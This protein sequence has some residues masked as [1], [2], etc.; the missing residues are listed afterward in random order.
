[1]DKSL[2]NQGGLRILAWMLYFIHVV[3]L[4]LCEI[5]WAHYACN[6]GRC[7]ACISR[8]SSTIPAQQTY[9]EGVEDDSQIDRF[10]NFF[11]Y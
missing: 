5:G 11:Q 9:R 10:E 8:L 2:E 1:M 7:T 3:L 4:L 6:N